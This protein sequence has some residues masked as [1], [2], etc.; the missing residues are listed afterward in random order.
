M[1]LYHATTTRRA[2]DIIEHGFRSGRV[3]DHENVVFFADQPLP[4][5][6]DTAGSSWIVIDA[7]PALLALDQYTESERAWDEE[8]Y[9]AQCY[10][11]PIDAV[12]TRARWEEQ[13][14]HI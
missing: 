7:D 10:C 8:Q 5:F 3:W 6:G 11:L 4:D 1:K 2:S 9:H 14:H 12:N 13:G